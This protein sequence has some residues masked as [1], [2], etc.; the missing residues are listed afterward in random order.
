MLSPS[1][2]I[3]KTPKYDD[4]SHPK[5][6]CKVCNVNTTSFYCVDCSA[7][8]TES[9]IIGICNPFSEHERQCYYEHMK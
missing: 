3:V 2:F 6:S 9:G 4:K 1:T 8:P 5:A 7:K